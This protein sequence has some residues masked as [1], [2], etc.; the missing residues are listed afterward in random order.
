MNRLSMENN[1]NA[2][3]IKAAY[4][5]VNQYLK[6]EQVTDVDAPDHELFTVW[7]CKALQNN[8][9]LIGCANADAAGMYFE[10]TYNGDRK[11]I[12]LDVY[13]KAD[14]VC[15]PLKEYQDPVRPENGVRYVTNVKR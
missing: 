4:E 8:K 10:V 13:R 14:N 12:Y 1:G 2:A 9:A 11:E 15:I 3:F 7:I 5:A 6:T